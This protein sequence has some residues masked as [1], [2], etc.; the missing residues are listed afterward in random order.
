MRISAIPMNQCLFYSRACIL[1]TK[2]MFNPFTVQLKLV[3][4]QS[5]EAEIAQSALFSKHP[6]MEGKH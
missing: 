6:E 4:V 3:D 2:S 5:A 1:F